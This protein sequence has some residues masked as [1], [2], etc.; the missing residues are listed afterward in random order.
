MA[1][2][3]YTTFQAALASELDRDDMTSDIPD[4]IRLAEARIKRDVR[5]REMIQRDAL[6]V[7]DRYVA[8]PSKFLE[9]YEIRLLTDPVTVLEYL[10]PH[11][12]TRM[13]RAGTGKPKFFTVHNEFEFDIDADQSYSGEILFYENFDALETTATNDLLTN[14]P[15][16]YFY[17]SLLSAA[18]RLMHDER[19]PLWKGLYEEAVSRANKASSRSRRSGPMVSRVV[20][21]GP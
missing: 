21:R 7:N 15:D 17:G 10:Q 14:H 16:I 4:F 13:R 1:F 9:A 6:T 3:D 18:T 5:I 20:G 12:M 8:I 19:I 11:E 2:T